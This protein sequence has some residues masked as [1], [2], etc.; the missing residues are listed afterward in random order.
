MHILQVD[1]CLPMEKMVKTYI[2]D[3]KFK[4]ECIEIFLLKTWCRN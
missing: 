3:S 4:G 2:Y 1:D